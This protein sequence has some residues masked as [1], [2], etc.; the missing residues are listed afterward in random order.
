M[1][2]NNA[3]QIAASGLRAQGQRLRVIAENIANAD[4]VAKSP[5][6]DPYRRKLITF[7]DQLDK[8]SGAD[9]VALNKIETDQTDFR[10]KYDP[11][12]PS[13]DDK[14]YVRFPNVNTLIEMADMRE[15]ERSYEANLKTIEATRGMMLK[16]IDLLR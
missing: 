6:G 2:L 10:V 7:K 13:A 14:G 3:L 8:A 16:T 11:G 15:A 1:D 9:I 4:S 5:G 12:H